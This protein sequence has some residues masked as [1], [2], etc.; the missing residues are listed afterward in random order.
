MSSSD[1]SI[2]ILGL[3]ENNI[4]NQSFDIPHNQFNVITGVSGS[5]KSTIAFDTIYAE[6]ARRYIE[7]FSPYTRQFLDRLKSPDLDSIHGVRPSIALK[8]QNR[9]STSRSTVGT[10]TEINDYLKSLWP[11]IATCSCPKCNKELSINS[12]EH[13]INNLKNENID[14]SIIAIGF[15]LKISGA[16]SLRSLI[17]TLNS[18][19]L[20]KY[21]DRNSQQISN[22]DE[23]LT[24]QNSPDSLVIIVD[25]IKIKES[26]GQNEQSRMTSS[27]IQSFRF[28]R[29]KITIIIQNQNNKIINFNAGLSCSSCNIYLDPPRASLFNFN[30][31]IGACTKCKGFGK[32]LKF[33]VNLCIPDPRKSIKDGAIIIWDSP[34]TSYERKKLLK[35]CEEKKISITQPWNELNIQDQ[36]LIINGE[37]KFWGIAGWFE[38]L[39]TKSYKMHVRVFLSRYRREVECDSCN[40]NRL[41]N[42]A[43]SYKVE[44]KTLPE[45]WETPLDEFLAFFSN[46]FNKLT[47]YSNNFNKLDHRLLII[48]EIIERAKYLND[49]GLNYLTLN[50]QTRTLSG[51]ESQRVNLT[52]ILGARLVNSTIVLDEPTVGLH[53]SDTHRL[54]NTISN[55]RDKGNTIVVV[56]HDKDVI[57]SAD[58]IIDIGPNAGSKGGEILYNGNLNNFIKVQNSK[59]ALHIARDLLKISPPI[60]SRSDHYLKVN[61]AKF[62]NLKNITVQIPYNKKTVVTGVSGSGK[63]TLVKNCI[64]DNYQIYKKTG[65]FDQKLSILSDF[66]QF[67]EIT[68][69][70]QSPIGSSSRSNPATYSGIWDHI[71]DLL[72]DLDQSQKLGL[73]KSSF[74]FNVDG[75]RCNVC[76]GKGQISIEMQFLPDVQVECESCKGLR[77]Q[78]QILAIKLNG[79]SVLE[80]LNS[81]I[82]EIHELFS[83]EGIPANVK[84]QNLLKPFRDLGLGYLRIGQPLSEVSGG[85]AQRIKLASYLSGNNRGKKIL[86]ILD[87][88]TTGLHPSNIDDLNHCLDQLIE[89]KHTLLIVE[90]NLDIIS[91]ADYLIELGPTGGKNG[92]N[93]IIQ[94][95]LSDAFEKKLDSQTLK[96]L[97]SV[98]QTKIKNCKANKFTPLNEIKIKGARHHNLKNIDVNFPIN[99][100]SVVTGVSGSGKSSLTFDILFNEGQRRFIECLSPYARQFITE[101]EKPDYDNIENLPPTISVSQRT[102]QSSGVSTLA[103]VSEVYQF[104]RLLYAKAGTQLCPKDGELIGAGDT[105][106]IVD[107]L[108]KNYSDQTIYIFAPAISGRKGF[109]NEIFQRAYKAEITKA[110]IDGKIVSVDPNLRLERHKL[111]WIS[112][113]V[114]AIKINEKKRDLLKEAVDQALILGSGSIEISVGKI[115]AKTETL[116]SNRCCPKCQQGYVPLD[117]QDFSFRSERG[118]C[119]TCRGKGVIEKKS[120]LITCPECSG[121]RLDKIGRNVQ[122]GGKKIHELTALNCDQLKNFL[123]STDNQE[124]LNPVI[125]PIYAELISRL[126]VISKVGLNYLSLNRDSSTLSGGET[127][128]LRLAKTLGSPITGVCYVLDEPTIGLHPHDQESLIDLIKELRDHGNTIIAVEHDENFIKQADH[129]FDFGPV[130]GTNGGFLIAHGTPRQLLE[131]P[132]SITGFALKNREDFV[133]ENNAK[134]E[135]FIE[136]SE[137]KVNNLKS[138]NAKIPLGSLTAVCGKSGSGKSSLVFGHLLPQLHEEIQ[139]NGKKQRR[140]IKNQIASD[141]INRVI[142]IDQSPIGKTS[143]SIPASFLGIFDDI[144]VIFSMTPE[145]KSNGFSASFFSFNSGKGKCPVCEGRG[146]IKTPMSF[147]PDAFTTCD[148]CKG[149]RYNSQTELIKYKD[150]SIGEVLNLTFKEAREIFKNHNKIKR[151]LDIVQDL[152]IDYL[153]LGQPSN[154]LSGGEAQRIKIAKEL[155]SLVSSNTLYL[156]DEPTIGLHLNDVSKLISVLKKLVSQNNTVVVI[157]HDL[158]M[159]RSADYLIELGPEAGDQGGKIIFEGTPKKLMASKNKISYTKKYL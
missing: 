16:S 141:K 14:N 55:L 90:H 52:S 56:E 53:P 57:R 112:L 154:T 36:N 158:D 32:N 103:T 9:Q 152:G 86:F 130:G 6:G 95:Y 65:S 147:M 63:S 23:L 87:E 26:I 8:Q 100:F 41:K 15:E 17:M 50:R 30:S 60:T 142:Q 54:I 28:G 40:G 51:G 117:P 124:R 62:N 71:R 138:I 94:D 31:P 111:H 135:N 140:G 39:Q 2:K 47:N 96:Y 77:F 73:T 7:T 91:K 128:R 70:D 105:K 110:K 122:F 139:K 129:V 123:L 151:I 81:T 134:F 11:L 121:S 106:S 108:I 1:N 29:D 34:S 78:D 131:S 149:S 159:I 98:N 92:G 107:L 74:S 104:L 150:K 42:E 44:N 115:D 22:L 35:F 118:V 127:Q 148:F 48:G 83:D 68:L 156:L 136:I 19:G 3:K 113:L 85:E 143:T 38:Y 18:E 114:G 20:I 49:I 46:I 75:G 33:D 137:A 119:K 102:T 155:G 145:A 146:V 21:Y 13:I 10:S 69:I 97:N 61:N 133:F 37:K 116:S 43:L 88:P 25:R 125:Q 66:E 64:F 76:K 84:I 24:E 157:E 59:T 5:G 89:N 99:K 101:G 67:D 93:I 12:P 82:D 4:K 80:L 144:R 72:A 79:K 58:N 109:H 120:S 45:L 153:K 132:N 27:I 126:N